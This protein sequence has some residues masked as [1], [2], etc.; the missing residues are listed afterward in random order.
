MSLN[1]DDGMCI[2]FFG[3]GRTFFID[4]NISK[5]KEAIA[6]IMRKAEDPSRKES[7][8]NWRKGNDRKSLIKL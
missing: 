2:E 5:K 1:L 8:K 6:T 4:H 7:A 3:F